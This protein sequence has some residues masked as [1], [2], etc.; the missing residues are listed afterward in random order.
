MTAKS[1]RHSLVFSCIG[2]SYAHLFEPIFFVVA[3]VLPGELGLSYEAVL[4]L[5]IAGKL[6]YGIA[7]P[8]SGWCG[9]RWGATPMMGV[10]F[11]GLGLS[12]VATG[13]AQSP[14]QM[15]V[16]LAAVGLFGSI[17]HP[18]G[19]AWLVRNAESHGKALGV[20]G[21]FGGVGPAMAG[22]L[23]GGLTAW[24]GWR[25]AFIVPGIAV[26]LTGL[27][28]VWLLRRGEIVELKTDRKVTPPASR[29][30]TIRV[31][32]ILSLTLL[33]SGLIYQS[34]QPALPKLF[35]E[36]MAL[37]LGDNIMGI[38]GAIMVVYLVAG[39]LQIVAGHLA[40]R[41]PLKNVYILMY[42]AQVPLLWL[43]ASFSGWPL[44]GV[45]LLMVTF[46]L[47][48]I[49]AENSML[50]RYTP[51][52]WRGT[53]FGL[54]FILSFGVSGLGVPMVSLIRVQTGGFEW[55]FWILAAL[56]LVIVALGMFLPKGEEVR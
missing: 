1:A 15:A 38:G 11:L 45:A 33:C 51:A 54:K 43:A 29:G 42:V 6:L 39:L 53:A 44:L 16:A 35:E 49:P 26:F 40:D 56:A 12:A 41:Y 30:E 3:L 14:M 8:V 17:Y 13:L 20:N 4:A 36:R 21:V 52:K 48:G 50:A 31:G 19:I 7:A 28:F 55:L 27:V 22:V 23:A 47:G 2:H 24:L 10:Y 34:T 46:N 37:Q 18:V 5:V 25:S 9:D 32:I